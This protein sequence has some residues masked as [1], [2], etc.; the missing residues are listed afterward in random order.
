MNTVVTSLAS[1]QP[2]HSSVFE[3]ALSR[4]ALH[5]RAP[6]VFAPGAHERMSASYTFLST[7]RVLAALSSAGFLPVEARQSARARSPVHARHLIRLRRRFETIELRDAIPEILFLNSHD[8]TSAYQ[9]RVG[10]FRV[11]CTNGLVVSAGVFPVW[12]VMHRGDVVEDVV[13]AALQISERFEALAASVQRME[14]TPLDR[15]QQLDFAQE[16][17]ALRFPKDLQGA[18]EPS[19]LLVPRRPEDIGNDLWHTFNVV[20]ENILQ[21]GIPRRSPSQRLTRTRRI[22]AIREDVR[23]NSRLWELA[24]ARAA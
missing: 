3:N 6:A 18:V 14:R 15:L 16:A 8:G 10:L 5:E 22:T 9:L 23:L 11:V 20:Q 2:S 1:R 21:G 4:E 12:R 17:L 19:R 24:V 13:Q 7:E